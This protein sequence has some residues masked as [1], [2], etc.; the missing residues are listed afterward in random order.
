MR[1][2][3]GAITVDGNTREAI[4]RATQQMVE[5]M[6]L[7]NG[8]LP[9]DVGA[10]IFSATEDITA[11]FPA[12]GARQI[13]GF[14]AVPLFDARQMAVEGGLPMCIRALLLVDTEKA[15]AEVRHVY[16]G[17]AK[18]LRPDLGSR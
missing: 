3:R 15:Q 17:G 13:P 16:M 7:V 2:I 11:T 14:D 12:A 5:E 10:A 6:L 18:G 8:I 4:W 9:E 1:G